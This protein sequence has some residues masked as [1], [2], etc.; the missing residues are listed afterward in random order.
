MLFRSRRLV[1]E[2]V[3][4]VPMMQVAVRGTHQRGGGRRGGMAEGARPRLGRQVNAAIRLVQL[5]VWRQV[6]GMTQ[7]V[8]RAG[9]QRPSARWVQVQSRGV[10]AREGVLQIT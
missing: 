1:T 5:S 4:A 6:S 7:R 9:A 3:D 8:C 2:G 10:D